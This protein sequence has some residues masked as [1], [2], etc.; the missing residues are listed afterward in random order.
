MCI[1][2][3]IHVYAEARTL[4]P[5]VVCNHQ[6]MDS[7]AST[8]ICFPDNRTKECNQQALVSP[9]SILIRF[10]AQYGKTGLLKGRFRFMGDVMFADVQNVPLERRDEFAC[11]VYPQNVPTELLFPSIMNKEA[12]SN[13]SHRDILWVDNY[14]I[15]GTNVP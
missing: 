4:F 9:S 5:F 11:H 13:M 6:A 3:K 10:H 12:N 15:E 1:E 14:V 2:S 8:S 7:S